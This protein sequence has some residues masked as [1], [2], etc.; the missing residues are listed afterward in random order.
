MLFVTGNLSLTPAEEEPE[1]AKQEH[2]P[3]PSLVGMP[4]DSAKE[5]LKARKLRMVVRAERPDKTA[6]KGIIVEQDPLPDSELE[7]GGE[8]AII[9][10][11]G[12]RKATVP[13]V[14]GK[15]LEEAKKLVGEAGLEI[16][17]ISYAGEGAP[18]SVTQITPS[19]GTEVNDGATVVLVAAPLD[20]EVPSLVGMRTAL[21]KKKIKESGLKVGKIR[22]RYNEDR[23]ANLVL[24]QTPAAGTKAAPDSAVDL[25]L[26]EE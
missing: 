16:G 20:V 6:E 4:T 2:Q 15:P 17:S 8:V 9:V 25:V 1:V 26:N 21:A 12:P 5:L 24:S 7:I 23:P 10:S 14:V 19:A 18:G 3:V 11:S 13:T 22:W